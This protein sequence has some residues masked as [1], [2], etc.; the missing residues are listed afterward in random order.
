MDWSLGFLGVF[1]T[2]N[3]FEGKSSMYLPGECLNLPDSSTYLMLCSFCCFQE[4]DMPL[5]DILASYGIKTIATEGEQVRETWVSSHFLAWI[6]FLIYISSKRNWKR[7]LYSSFY[8]DF[9]FWNLSGSHFFS[10]LFV[11]IILNILK[12]F[13]FRQA[14][15]SIYFFN[16][17]MSYTFWMSM[18]KL[19]AVENHFF[20][21]FSIF[22]SLKIEI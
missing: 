17:G 16:I 9:R 6:H 5:A 4:Q 14:Q 7:S 11:L 3:S 20:F 8:T 10:V 21:S 22:G 18:Q 2:F 15:N 1:M 13:P 12:I 19:L